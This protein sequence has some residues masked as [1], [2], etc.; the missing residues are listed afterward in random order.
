MPGA[1]RLKIRR[2]WEGEQVLMEDTQ[3]LSYVEISEVGIMCHQPDR[4]QHLMRWSDLQTVLLETTDEGPFVDDV[5]WIL[6]AANGTY[7]VTQG[8]PGEGE[9][10]ARM[11]MLPDFDNDAVIAAMSSVES[12]QFLCWQR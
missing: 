12:Q 2:E 11:Q 8:A 10:F 9:L 7:R 5:W 3:L 4:N 6:I 1:K